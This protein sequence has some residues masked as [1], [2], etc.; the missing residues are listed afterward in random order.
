MQYFCSSF[1]KCVQMLFI[2]YYDMYAFSCFVE[3]F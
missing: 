2:D 3:L 1:E